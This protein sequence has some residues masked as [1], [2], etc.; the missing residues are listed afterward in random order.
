MNL[1]ARFIGFL[2]RIAAR[3]LMLGEGRGTDCRHD[4]VVDAGYCWYAHCSCTRMFSG[5][6][7]AEA[8]SKLKDHLR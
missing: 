6:T 5:A 8:E 4:G 7:K 1:A 2:G 3:L